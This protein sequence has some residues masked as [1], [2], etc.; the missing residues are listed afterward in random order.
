MMHLT[1]DIL[2]CLFAE[3]PS[4]VIIQQK[5]ETLHFGLTRSDTTPFTY[6]KKSVSVPFRPSDECT[7]DIETLA[8]AL[9]ALSSA[10]T[11][12]GELIEGVEGVSIS[13]Q[14]SG[15]TTPTHV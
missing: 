11:F 13:I 15:T 3:E 7:V 4:A 10:A 12:A 6:S 8:S 9:N 1:K 2:L 5:P 14:A